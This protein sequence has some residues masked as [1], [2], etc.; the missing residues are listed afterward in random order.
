MQTVSPAA[1]ACGTGGGGSATVT[2]MF[3]GEGSALVV[4]VAPPFEN[5]PVGE[6]II[7]A[8]R[9]ARVPPFSQRAFSTTY[10]IPLR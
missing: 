2:V 10:P 8:V 3:S 7:R 9:G 5:T 6:C 1:R 4:T